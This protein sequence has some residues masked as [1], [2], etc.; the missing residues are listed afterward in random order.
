MTSTPPLDWVRNVDPTLKEVDAVPLTGAAPPF[1]WEQLA[2]NLAQCFEKDQ[3]LLSPGEIQ[4][5]SKETLLEGLGETP[6]P[7]TF[8][9]PTLSGT[10]CWLMPEQE[11][12]ALESLLLTKESHPLTFQDRALSESFYRFLTIEVLYQ[13]SQTTFEKSL[14]PL[15]STQS[16]IPQEA[17][18]T[19]DVSITIQQQTLWGRLLISPELRQSWAA[20]FAQNTLSELSTEL[21]EQAS[22]I[23]H[24]EAGKVR[25][26]LN[27]W[28]QLHEGDLLLLDECTLDP[29]DLTGHVSITINGKTA[30]LGTVNNEGNIEI[31]ELS[32]TQKVEVPMA[33]EIEDAGAENEE[34]NEASEEDEFDLDDDTLGEIEDDITEEEPTDEEEEETPTSAEA[35]SEIETEQS[36]GEEEVSEEE[37]SEE[38]LEAKSKQEKSAPVAV[39]SI[40]EETPYSA[41]EIPLTVVIEIGR[42]QMNIQKLLHLE[43]GNLLDLNIR[44][45]NGVTLT[46]NG[47]PVGKGELIRLGET[48]GVRLLTLGKK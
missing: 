9:I 2:S 14:I 17:A 11:M 24:V 42:I 33:K 15:L 22:I 10:L 16:N 28:R 27:E 8:S 7:L 3:I 20:H 26:S 23:A 45:E 25:L 19:L 40:V 48:L 32:P 31:L 46:V 41:D 39:Q 30:F 29:T 38:E 12:L 18:L 43:P 47:A 13:L 44:P 34:T 4:W 5:R 35:E 21:S 37:V 1:P 36:I 6:Y